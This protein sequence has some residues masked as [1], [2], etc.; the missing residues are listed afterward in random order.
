MT[1]IAQP[2]TRALRKLAGIVG[3]LLPTPPSD[4]APAPDVDGRRPMSADETDVKMKAQMRDGRGAG[5][6]Q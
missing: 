5:S 3:G 6:N 1:S 4:E 2:I